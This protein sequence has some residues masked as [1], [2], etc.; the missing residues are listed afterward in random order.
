MPEPAP[1][2]NP[3]KIK[4]I[5]REAQERNKTKKA[6]S[7]TAKL[8][9]HDAILT[10]CAYGMREKAGG[11]QWRSVVPLL[12]YELDLSNA[13]GLWADLAEQ[14]LIERTD[15]SGNAYRVTDKGL[16]S[17]PHLTPIAFG[18]DLPEQAKAAPQE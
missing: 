10:I 8:V 7:E 16:K 14:Q 1:V 6:T 12:E 13:T 5:I 15:Q 3:A 18:V 4:S 17:R 2:L 11:A 9:T